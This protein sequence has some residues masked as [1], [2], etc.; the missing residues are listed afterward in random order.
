[1][2]K[3]IQFLNMNNLI[4]DTIE[5]NQNIWIKKARGLGVT[6]F[7]IRYLAW[8]I[9]SSSELE[10]KSIF[11]V[12]GTREEFANYVKKKMEQLFESR[13]PDLVLDSKYTELVLKKTW[14]KVMPTKKYQRHQGIYGCRLP[15]HRRGRLFQHLRNR[16]N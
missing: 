2:A 10:G 13:F 14:I 4:F 5:Q 6:T 8:K 7:L 3:S 15:I 9:L 12:S 1:M 16:K 11:I